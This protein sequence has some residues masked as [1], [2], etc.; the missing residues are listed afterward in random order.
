[1]SNQNLF[2]LWQERLKAQ[3]ARD[4]LGYQAL[5]QG[6]RLSL[7]RGELKPNLRMPTSR[8]LATALGVGRN[9]VVDAYSNLTAEGLLVARG[10][11]GT[12]VSHGIRPAA[13]SKRQ[14]RPLLLRRLQSATNES[15]T[16]RSSALDW[17]MGQANT[18]LLPLSVWRTACR[19][20]GRHALPA[21]YGHPQGDP[22]LRQSL[23][24]WLRAKR[25]LAIS[26]EQ[27]RL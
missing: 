3:N 18:R 27:S 21:G 26:A 4:P 13:P 17:R 11:L 25:S 12:F 2:S 16:P 19:E 15:A 7:L 14:T 6:L 9:I 8:A 22:Q 5:E 24:L 1:M 20:A 23:A 10:R